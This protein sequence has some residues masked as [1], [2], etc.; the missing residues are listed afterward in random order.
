MKSQSGK[1]QKHQQHEHKLPFVTRA[2]A[3][4]M[5]KPLIRAIYIFR[6]NLISGSE[7]SPSRDS[8]EHVVL[9]KPALFL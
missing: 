2:G 1:Q 4:L 9:I 5:H 6:N 3:Q 7:I 8:N